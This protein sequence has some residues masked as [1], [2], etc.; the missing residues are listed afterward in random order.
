MTLT[1]QTDIITRELVLQLCNFNIN[2][3]DYINITKPN[4]TICNDALRDC[5]ITYITNGQNI[6][7]IGDYAFYNIGTAYCYF[8]NCTHVGKYAFANSAIEGFELGSNVVLESHALDNCKLMGC[9]IIPSI[10]GDYAFANFKYTQI[11]F[12]NVIQIGNYAFDGCEN[13][14]SH[15]LL[16]NCTEIG[17]YA[18][19]GCEN[20]ES[21]IAPNC[22]FVDYNAFYGTKL[23]NVEPS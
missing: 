20:L 17:R 15:I 5:P 22:T 23:W 9:S 6:S 12:N 16:N 14:P 19:R 10:I 4:S 7:S 11:D 1:F 8:P 18:F 2:D 3:V 21:L 13:F